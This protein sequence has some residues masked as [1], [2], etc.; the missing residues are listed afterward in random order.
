[1]KTISYVIKDELGLH[2]RPA[3][4]LVKRA[5]AYKD[6]DI[7]IKNEENGKEADCKRVIS[8]MSLGVKKGNKIT[9]T[10][11]GA[12]ETTAASELQSFLAENV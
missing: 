7:K 6:T 4:I 10:F 3:G 12:D 5:A 8:V 9:L 1:M 11:S 2:A